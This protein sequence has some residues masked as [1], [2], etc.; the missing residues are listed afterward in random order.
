MGQSSSNCA[1][2]SGWSSNPCKCDISECLIIDF[3]LYDSPMSP[4]L[5]QRLAFASPATPLLVLTDSRTCNPMKENYSGICHS[6]VAVSCMC[7]HHQ[8]KIEFVLEFGDYGARINP[9][10]YHE[11][12]IRQGTRNQFPFMQFQVIADNVEVKK[13]PNLHNYQEKQKSLITWIKDFIKRHERHPYN[14]ATFNCK[15]FAQ[16]LMEAAYSKASELSL[17][18]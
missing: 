3:N 14:L 15:D 1:E 13:Q 5:V 10:R 16:K 18:K 11:R 8:K 12:T 7:K 6:Y 9:G 2:N 4:D 17:R